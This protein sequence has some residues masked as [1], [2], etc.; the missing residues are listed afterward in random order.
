MRWTAGAGKPFLHKRHQSAGAHDIAGI[1][2]SRPARRSVRLN[3]ARCAAKTKMLK[4][5]LCDMPTTAAYFADQSNLPAGLH[6]TI[7]QTDWSNWS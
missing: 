7:A 6:R 2:H 3:Q 5:D 4:G 1:A